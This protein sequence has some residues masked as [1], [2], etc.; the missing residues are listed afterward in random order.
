MKLN[1]VSLIAVAMIVVVT[2]VLQIGATATFA[3]EQGAP[4]YG[5]GPPEKDPPQPPSTTSS[6]GWLTQGYWR[7]LWTTRLGECEVTLTKSLNGSVLTVEVEGECFGLVQ[8]AYNGPSDE[9]CTMFHNG[10]EVSPTFGNV[11]T[12]I[13]HPGVE[14][15]WTVECK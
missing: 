8:L 12:Y 5:Y 11:F 4:I 1:K 14:G 10:N 9:T 3:A 2:L 7:F 15:Q 6:E 13:P